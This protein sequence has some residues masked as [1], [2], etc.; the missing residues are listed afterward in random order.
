MGDNGD[1]QV[2]LN[3][4]EA[5]EARIMRELREMD[6]KAC[7]GTAADRRRADHIKDEPEASLMSLLL[8]CEK[9]VRDAKGYIAD[10][11]PPLRIV[12]LRH[13]E[14]G[15]KSATYLSR[16]RNTGV[17]FTVP[18]TIKEYTDTVKH[19]IFLNQIRDKIKAR[20][21]NSPEQYL[22]DMRLLAKNTAQFNKGLDHTWVVQHARFLLEA[23][24]DAVTSRRRLFYDIEDAVRQNASANVLRTN[25]SSLSAVG[26][27]KRSLP[28]HASDKSNGQVVAIPAI[29]SAIEVYWPSYRRW[30]LAYITERDGVEVHLRY[31]EDNSLQWI[32]L[33]SGF[34]WRIRNNKTA[35]ATKGKRPHEHPSKKRKNATGA[36][37][38]STRNELVVASGGITVED[39]DAF[40]ID[41]YTKFEDFKDSVIEQ[42]QDHLSRVDR[43][44]LRS[45]ALSR[46]LIQVED[47]HVAVEAQLKAMTDRFSKLENK[48]DQSVSPAKLHRPPDDEKKNG[49]Y[50]IHNGNVPS[51][52]DPPVEAYHS[53]IHVNNKEPE[54]VN[55]KTNKEPDIATDVQA[56]VNI[57]N[58][59][60]DV[61][62]DNVD[63]VTPGANCAVIDLDGSPPEEV[64]TTRSIVPQGSK[65]LV[66]AEGLTEKERAKE[67]SPERDV[68]MEDV[69]DVEEGK[70]GEKEPCQVE[71]SSEEET[72]VH[73]NTLV[74][75]PVEATPT[76]KLPLSLLERENKVGVDE[77]EKVADVKN[78]DGDEESSDESSGSSEFSESESEE[79]K[80][81]VQEEEKLGENEN[82][83]KEEKHEE[84]DALE[85]DVQEE[86][87]CEEKE[88][89]EEIGITAAN[90]HVVEKE[91]TSEKEDAQRVA[92]SPENVD[93]G[94]M[95]DTTQESV[96]EE[97][98]SEGVSMEQEEAV[99]GKPLEF[100]SVDEVEEG[101][102][103]VEEV[104]SGDI[105]AA[106]TKVRKVRREVMTGDENGVGVVEDN[107]NS[108]D[109]NGEETDGAKS[110]A[111]RRR[112]ANTQEG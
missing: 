35:A 61:K 112:E 110:E 64:D 51:N 26:K 84:K 94:V 30:F 41:L 47:T 70:V 20:K 86:E 60:G 28:Q 83:P 80:E 52:N 107:S 56:D 25:S 91:L 85:E 22:E 82:A 40:K 23:A 58:D 67:G 73:E 81:E 43:T 99:Q 68:E 19:P 100:V 24:E 7:A 4:L 102:R 15:P 90:E 62:L 65:G 76:E 8:E 88:G 54:V 103:E 72:I 93:V 9:E 31:D 38:P 69:K 96:E 37:S 42:L 108:E 98:K 78:D 71:K 105:Q 79:E 59:D 45:D 18:V 101:G 66:Q 11:G 46:V 48:F 6:E 44:L 95:E 106:A 36:A 97:I 89:G 92:E 53:D 75:T 55:T 111:E 1:V 39:L 32:N 50:R 13:G 34:K 12:R 33:E 21:Y 14:T 57:E 5:E 3:D 77:N 87:K 104:S 10:Q 17:D 16:P 29:G 2:Q 63:E 49:S 109:E 27:R 74:D